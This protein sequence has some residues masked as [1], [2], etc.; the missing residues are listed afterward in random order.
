[1][2]KPT[3]KAKNP[4]KLRKLADNSE[5][6]REISSDTLGASKNAQAQYEADKDGWRPAR[7]NSCLYIYAIAKVMM[8][9][10][11][12]WAKFIKQPFWENF[13]K[14]P[15]AD[16]NET[17]ILRYVAFYVWKS[18]SRTSKDR[19]CTYVRALK[20]LMDDNVRVDKLVE[21]IEDAGGI[22]KLAKRAS[23]AAPG[24]SEASSVSDS[25]VPGNKKEQKGQFHK[26]SNENE[27]SNRSISEK[28]PTR[29][30]SQQNKQVDLEEDPEWWERENSVEDDKIE[31]RG[32]DPMG[33]A[34]IEIEIDAKQR[35]R[36]FALKDGMRRRI[37]L[38]CDGQEEDW[39]RF[40]L[41]KF[42]KMS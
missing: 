39:Y 36:L 13:P 4:R 1:M 41:S 14:S 21:T 20:M 27:V 19:A 24:A 28:N 3:K 2:K 31:R 32:F 12:E 8:S 5:L 18:T 23:K 42:L 7:L 33:R 11:K 40:R 29:N 35:K 10:P 37:E 9:K 26:D 15:R 30:N 34:T 17:K 25:R 22:E 6:M 16:A 38:V